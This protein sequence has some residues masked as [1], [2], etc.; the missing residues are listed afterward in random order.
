MSKGGDRRYHVPDFDIEAVD[1][2]LDAFLHDDPEFLGMLEARYHHGSDHMGGS[3]A[4]D[5]EVGGQSNVGQVFKFADFS[6]DMQGVLEAEPELAAVVASLNQDKDWAAV[7]SVYGSESGADSVEHMA[8]EVE[9]ELELFNPTANSAL[10]AR[11]NAVI[12]YLRQ[13]MSEVEVVKRLEQGLKSG[14]APNPNTPLE[15]RVH[16]DRK[17]KNRPKGLKYKKK[18][19]VV[20]TKRVHQ[21]EPKRA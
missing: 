12:D 3:V 7:V 19:K 21:E 8:N 6:H 20:K 1:Q 5:A 18:G 16:T 4:S 17:R 13:R 2:A 9:P 10:A 15:T 11:V 14:I